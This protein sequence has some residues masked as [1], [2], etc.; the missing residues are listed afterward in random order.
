MADEACFLPPDALALIRA[1][2]CDFLN[3]KLM[4]AGGILNSVRIAHLAD[5]GQVMVRYYGL[6]ANTH[7]GK[8]KKASLRISTL[9]MAEESVEYS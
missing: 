8:V 4:K 9:R 5:K 3:I 2:A 6:Y 7:R 1:G